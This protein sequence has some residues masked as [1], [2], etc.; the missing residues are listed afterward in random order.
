MK[1]CFPLAGAD[2]VGDIQ[3]A[4]LGELHW[5]MQKVLRAALCRGDQSAKV[6]LRACS[7]SQVSS[8]RHLQEQHRINMPSICC[9]SVSS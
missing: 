4:T 1:K 8:V 2:G 6:W 7:A 5:L 9:V 3:S